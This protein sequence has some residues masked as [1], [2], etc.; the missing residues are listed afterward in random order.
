MKKL[1]ITVEG[2]V[3]EVEVEILGS[4]TPVAAAPAAAPVAAPAPVAAAPVAA[5]ASAPKAAAPAAPVAAGAGDVVCPL[6]GNG[7]C[8]K[9]KGRPGGKVGRFAR[10]SRSDENEH[11]HQCRQSRYGIQNLR[12]GRPECPR[13][14]AFGQS[15]VILT[16]TFFVVC[17]LTKNGAS[18]ERLF[19]QR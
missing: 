2:K 17:R 19:L 11:S 15:L 16:Q 1:R 4:R 6:A 18:R 7:R 10:Y 8:G 13:R 9:R 14:T 5:P 3:Y 12:C